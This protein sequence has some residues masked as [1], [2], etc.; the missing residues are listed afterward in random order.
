MLRAPTCSTS[1]YRAT[2]STCSGA[3]T[4]VTTASPVASRAS[5]SSSRPFSFRPW[6]L[7]GLVRGLN[8]PPRRP[9]APASLTMWATSRICSRLSTEHG[10][11][12]TP[13]WPP[14]TVSFEHC[15]ARSA[16]S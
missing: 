1:A 14:P 4:S 5:A 2:S 13:I 7:Y 10:P 16:P 8:A 9:V 12:M 15:D 6:K 11:A 3:I